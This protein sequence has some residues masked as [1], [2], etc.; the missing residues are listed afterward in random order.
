[1]HYTVHFD[2]LVGGNSGDVIYTRILVRNFDPTMSCFYVC[3]SFEG[4]PLERQGTKYQETSKAPKA[5][6][7]GYDVLDCVN[8]P[9]MS[10]T[11]GH[12]TPDFP[13]HVKLFPAFFFFS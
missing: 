7:G 5:I 2:H 4:T 3:H 6:Q 12:F 1:M 8:E 11:V 10:M 9:E 13:R